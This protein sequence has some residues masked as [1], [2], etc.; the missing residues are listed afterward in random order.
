MPTQHSTYNNIQIWRYRVT[1]SCVMQCSAICC[2]ESACS[3]GHIFH[4]TFLILLCRMNQVYHV[5]IALLLCILSC[6]AFTMGG[7]GRMGVSSMVRNKTP[8]NVNRVTTQQ[9]KYLQK[10]SSLQMN[11]FDD[12]FRYFS[13]L[14]KEA[15]AKHI[16][17]KVFTIITLFINCL[18]RAD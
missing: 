15:S 4:S 13:Q 18:H 9:R 1:I 12:A 14:N 6:S 3:W 2:D 17:I 8:G 5:I 7:S 16:L 10:S 11:F